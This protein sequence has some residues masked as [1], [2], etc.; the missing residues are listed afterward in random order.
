MQEKCFRRR[1]ARE[2]R[3]P[4]ITQ[5]ISGGQGT[6]LFLDV[7]REL[8]GQTYLPAQAEKR[9]AAKEAKKRRKENL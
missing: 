5:V 3:L 8:Y 6:L 7:L 4:E 9:L 2:P 1:T